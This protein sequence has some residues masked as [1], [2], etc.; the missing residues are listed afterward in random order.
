M[1]RVFRARDTT[2]GVD[3]AVKLLDVPDNLR[4]DLRARLR[5]EAHA[6]ALIRHPHV[7]RVVDV[8]TDGDTDWIAMDL[9]PGGSVEDR[10]EAGGPLSPRQA[11]AWHADVLDALQAAHQAAT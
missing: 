8:G 11:A 5:A 9:A 2:L 4:A 10:F 6:M 7:L 3:C 1:A